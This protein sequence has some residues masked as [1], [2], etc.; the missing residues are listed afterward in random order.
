MVNFACTASNENQGLCSDLDM[1]GTN[2]VISPVATLTDNTISVNFCR[3]LNTGDPLDYV[4]SEG[5]SR[6]S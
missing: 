5:S 2:N 6:C 4:L 3:K 1:G